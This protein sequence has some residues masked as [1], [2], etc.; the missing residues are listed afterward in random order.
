MSRKILIVIDMQNDFIDGSLGT[1]EALAI[2]PDVIKKIKEY[3][4]DDVFATRD[5]HPTNYL[6]T[7]EGR[8]LPVEHCIKGTDGWQIQSQ[9]SKLI[10]ADHI[11]DKPT[12]GS[13]SLA[14]KIKEISEKEPVE[15]ELV[16]LCTDICVVSN[17]LLLKAFMPE[18]KIS[19]D[20]A[21]CAGVTPEKHEA[22]LET[23][24]SCQVN[25]I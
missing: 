25:V 13:V 4:S 7:Q 22:A 18:I 12:F 9:I 11:F 16:G 24:R 21:C 20:S 8:N 5:T 15:I 19:V 1:R 3:S 6:E 17:A 10:R 2:V 23:M 14:E